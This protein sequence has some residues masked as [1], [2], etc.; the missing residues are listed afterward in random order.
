MAGAMKR[1]SQ[2]NPPSNFSFPAGVAWKAPD[3]TELRDCW[4]D[5]ETVEL[6]S[7]RMSCSRG[8]LQ[9]PVTLR[10]AWTQK[11]QMAK[12]FAEEEKE[13]FDTK[14]QEVIGFFFNREGS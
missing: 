14:G 1:I 3:G 5:I 2:A 10:A 8:S 4:G 7:G 9:Y 12:F 6:I 11:R 13:V